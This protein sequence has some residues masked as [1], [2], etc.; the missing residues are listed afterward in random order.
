MMKL[1]KQFP[2][3]SLLEVWFRMLDIKENSFDP[4]TQTHILESFTMVKALGI[5]F[6]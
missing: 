6:C 5:R 4:H 2:D 3:D 1:F